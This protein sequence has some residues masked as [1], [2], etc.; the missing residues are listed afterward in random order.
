[1]GHTIGVAAAPADA[2][3]HAGAH[4]RPDDV[5]TTSTDDGFTPPT[6]QDPAQPGR[7]D[8]NPAPVGSFT[9]FLLA[10]IALSAFVVIG[11]EAGW[12]G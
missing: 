10:V 8:P 11:S 6:N 9:A 4:T 1:M 5:M 3:S 2:A 12:L 7:P